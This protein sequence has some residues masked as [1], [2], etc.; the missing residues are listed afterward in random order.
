MTS[1][2]LPKSVSLLQSPLLATESKDDFDRIRDAF[3]DEIKPR[4]IVEQMYIA[5]IIYLTWEILRLRRCKDVVIS[6]RIRAA[7]EKLL[8]EIL[9]GPDEEAY[10]REDEGR[11]LAYGW[12]SN[13]QIK[14]QI[15]ERLHQF[16]LDESAVEALAIRDSMGEIE[17]LDRLLA[18]LESRRN[19]AL[20]CIVGWRSDLA[21][22]L[23][24]ASNRVIDGKV[25]ALEH[26]AKR[27]PTAA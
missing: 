27:P 17:Q 20:R 3:N 22:R 2:S 26:S 4:G 24:E 18:S 15:V 14:K 10:E 12:F 7:L 1:Q 8:P 9:R 13:K 19:K 16:H 21:G 5:D 11:E 23:R 6:S 25:M